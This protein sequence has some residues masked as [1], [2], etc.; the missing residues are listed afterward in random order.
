MSDKVTAYSEKIQIKQEQ[1]NRYVP[2]RDPSN[3]FQMGVFQSVLKQYQ[4]P[5]CWASLREGVQKTAQN[6]ANVCLGMC[7]CCET[8]IPINNIVCYM[9]FLLNFL[10]STNIVSL[11]G[12]GVCV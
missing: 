2:H 11:R 8:H 1:Q 10:S 5:I 6:L 7:V 9:P 4:S 12:R 3:C